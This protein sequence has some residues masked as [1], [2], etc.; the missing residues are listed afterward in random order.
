[1]EEKT[2]LNITYILGNGYDIQLGL[3]TA[4][5]DFYEY[6][7]K[8]RSKELENNSIFKEIVSDKIGYW[9][10]FELALGKYTKGNL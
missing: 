3:K 9:S 8:N 2:T 10:D 5:S 1:M 6:L 7:I 4:Y